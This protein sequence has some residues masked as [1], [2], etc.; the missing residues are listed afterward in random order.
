MTFH[1]GAIVNSGIIS[2][3]A[4]GIYVSNAKNAITID[5]NAGDHRGT[6]KLSANADVVNI[7]G[8]TSRQYRRP[9]QRHGQFRAGA[10]HLYLQQH[11]TN[12]SRV[13]V[14]NGTTLVVNGTS[15]SAITVNV[16]NG[17][18]LAGTGSITSAISINSGGTLEPGLPGTAGG[19]LNIA[20][21]LTFARRRELCRHHLR[22]RRASAGAVTGTATLGG[23]TVAISPQSALQTGTPYTILTDTGGGLGVGGNTFAPTD[24][25]RAPDRDAQLQQPDDVVL[26]FAAPAGCATGLNSGTVPCVLETGT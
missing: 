1:G 7:T 3:S 13:N 17:G 10:G 23:A 26:N 21:T 22:H 15:N 6:I 20:G 14:A 25:L 9:G 18:T 2:G 19:T 8:G 4:Y 16:S 24:Q 5:Q 11:L 12:V